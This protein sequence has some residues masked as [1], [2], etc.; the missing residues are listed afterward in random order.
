MRIGV[1]PLAVACGAM[2]SLL[3]GS[4][5]GFETSGFTGALRDRNG[6]FLNPS[7]DI[8][9][10]SPLVTFPFFVRRAV[11]TF[12][13]HGAP[14]ERVANDG[15]FLRENATHSAPTAT[16]IGHAT[17]LVQMEHLTFLTDPIWSERAS[18]FSFAGPKRVVPPGVAL[19]DLPPIDFVLVSHN[20]YDHLDTDT[21]RALAERN[22]RVRF[23]VPLGN[24]DVLASEGIRNVT[25][26]DWGHEVQLGPVRIV[27]LPTQHWSGRGPFD[28]RIALWGSYAVLGRERRFYF[29]GDSGYHPGFAEIGAAYGPFDL[30]A[31]PIGA[32]SPEAMMHAWHM[33][34]EEA[35]RAGADLEARRLVAIHFGTFDLA[36]EALDE[37][38]RRFRAAALASGR[39]DDEALVLKI[40]E[41]RAF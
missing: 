27:C 26:L 37:P 13:G 9:F 22:P 24:A 12:T 15:A 6:R 25:E 36:D 14:P 4:T 16:W 18:P 7:G 21:L 29:T 10:A 32:Y 8:P 41:T 28:A 2:L 40:G 1:V 34:P 20:H 30:A 31:V 39:S 17:L 38:P 23:I 5:V 3:A 35:I 19:D 33:S 11:T